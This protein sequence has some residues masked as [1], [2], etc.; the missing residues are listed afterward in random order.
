MEVTICN[1]KSEYFEQCEAL[2]RICYPSLDPKYHLQRSH[3]ENHL[4]LFPEGQHVAVTNGIVVGMGAS[5][6]V[7]FDMDHPEHKVDE[8]IAENYFTPHNP[9]GTW[10]YGADLCVHPTYRRYGIAS[11]IYDARKELVQT[12]GMRGIFAGAM[13]PGYQYYRA[14]L[15]VEEYVK[16]VVNG[17]IRDPTLTMQL[18]NGFVVRQILYDYLLDEELGNDVVL[19][20][21]EVTN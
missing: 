9:N 16:Q 5:L 6:R 7:N 18:R 19:I 11:R 4:K 10:L 15:S 12:L 2:Q 17:Q 21:W 14:T 8:I 3:L 20:V 1:T 13:T